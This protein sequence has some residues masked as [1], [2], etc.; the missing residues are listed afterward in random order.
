MTGEP[1]R[2][3]SAQILR[4]LRESPLP[5]VVPKDLPTGPYLKGKVSYP[6]AEYG[7]IHHVV[8]VPWPDD[9]DEGLA[10]LH[11]MLFADDWQY[12]WKQASLPSGLVIGVRVEAE[13]TT[14]RLSVPTGTQAGWVKRDIGR[15]KAQWGLDEG[16][17]KTTETCP[18][19]S[20]RATY[21]K[22]T[23]PPEEPACTPP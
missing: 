9:S 11:G 17:T 3:S 4:E 12:R 22:P 7:L 14:V 16:W 21:I 20:K 18:D 19:G 8:T 2:L 23:P 1:A 6:G 5:A 13:D 15:V 10:Q